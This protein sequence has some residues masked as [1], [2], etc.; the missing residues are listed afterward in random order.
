MPCG[1]CRLSDVAE[2]EWWRRKKVV[3]SIGV[4]QQ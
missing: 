3:F 4:D 2:A 1:V